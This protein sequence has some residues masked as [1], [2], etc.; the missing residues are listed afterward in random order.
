VISRSPQ[1]IEDCL[2]QGNSSLSDSETINI[3]IEQYQLER[4][5]VIITKYRYLQSTVKGFSLYAW[6][7]TRTAPDER[8]ARWSKLKDTQKRRQNKKNV[9]VGG[10]MTYRLSGCRQILVSICEPAG[11]KI[12]L[13]NYLAHSAVALQCYMAILEGLNP[14]SR[15]SD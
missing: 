10:T 8:R 4:Y 11:S 3:I 12:S 7:L 14:L 13:N 6:L 9:V 15:Y 5:S 1:Q 2:L